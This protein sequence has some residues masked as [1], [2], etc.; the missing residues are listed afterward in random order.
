MQQIPKRIESFCE[1]NKYR[2]QSIYYRSWWLV[3]TFEGK[4]QE[5]QLSRSSFYGVIRKTKLT[6]VLEGR[7]P[8][9]I[10][11][12]SSQFLIKEVYEFCLRMYYLRDKYHGYDFVSLRQDAKF[13]YPFS[14][15]LIPDEKIGHVEIKFKNLR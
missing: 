11:E 8:R 15:K 7:L 4:K 5:V 10:F 6:D 9:K 2:P 13:V 12:F 14:L 1:I 3:F